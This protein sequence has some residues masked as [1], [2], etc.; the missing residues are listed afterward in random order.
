MALFP[1]KTTRKPHLFSAPRPNYADYNGP[2]DGDYVRYVDSLMAWAEQEQ[3]RQ[4][5]KSQGDKCRAALDSQ[6]GRSAAQA[7][8]PVQG[9]AATAQPGSVDS[10]VERLKRTARAQVDKLQ[11]QVADGAK[12]RPAAA[13]QKAAPQGVHTAKWP[14]SGVLFFA[15]LIAVAIFA[16]D[17]L[18]VVIIGWVAL[19][20]IRTVRAAS[21]AGKP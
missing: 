9:V 1:A 10:T 12:N 7:V 20:V 4:R 6:W 16:T 5:L 14:A 19:G 8:P 11:Q 21:R 13:A 18:P 15:L 2:A 3:E 17:W